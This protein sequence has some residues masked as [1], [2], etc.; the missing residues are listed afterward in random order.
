M[1]MG[2]LMKRFKTTDDIK[3][4]DKLV[5]QIIG[6]EKAVRIVKKA[7]AQRRNVLLIGSP[8]TGKTM[9]A[10]AMAELRPTTDLED[11]LVYRNPN[12]ENKPLVKSVK[13]YPNPDKRPLGDGQ[14]R[15]T[16]AKEKLKGKTDMAQGAR[17]NVMPAVIAIIVVLFILSLTDIFQGYQIVVLAAL[18]LGIMI[19]GSAM[20]FVGSFKRVGMMPGVFESSEPKLIIDN[21]GMTHAP[22]VDG[23]GSKAGALFGDVR[24]DPLQSGGLGTPPHLRVESGAVHRA[25][26]GVLFIDEVADLEPRSQ[27]ELLTAMQEKKYPITGQS[28]MSSGAIVRT[29]P[30]PSDFLLVAAGNLMDIQK[31]HPALRSRIR[32]YGYEVYMESTMRDNEQN[33]DKLIKFI[34]QEVKKDGTHPAFRLRRLHGD[35]RRGKEEERKEEQPER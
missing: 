32:G 4:P 3:L 19:F 18:M 34:A 2:V 13:T 1:L 28:E 5:D 22:F 17:S 35:N 9:L 6:Q 25:N 23:T 7:S 33:R 26:K 31:M 14:G 8:G 27:Q 29:E 21:T 11:V 12:D 30:V 24:H 10:Q 20:L 15:L 16:V